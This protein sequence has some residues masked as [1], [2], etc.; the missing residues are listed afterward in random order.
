LIHI[1]KWKVPMAKSVWVV[2][3]IDH[4]APTDEEENEK[5]IGVYSSEALAH[6]AIERLRDKPGFRDYPKRWDIDE[7]V[8]DDDHWEDGFVTMRYGAPE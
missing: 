6:E 7:Y 3:H 1:E 5:L 2:W 4:D 8:L